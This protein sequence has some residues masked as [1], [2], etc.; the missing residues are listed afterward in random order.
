[1]WVPLGASDIPGTTVDPIGPGPRRLTLRN[2]G[3]GLSESGPPRRLGAPGGP[4]V[5]SGGARR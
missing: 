5:T 3:D 4:W 1:M 2:G